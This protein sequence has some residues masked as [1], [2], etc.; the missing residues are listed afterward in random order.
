[1]PNLPIYPGGTPGRGALAGWPRWGGRSCPADPAQGKGWAY[2]R[3]SGRT[4]EVR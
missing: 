3:Y 4:Q 2:R 1:M